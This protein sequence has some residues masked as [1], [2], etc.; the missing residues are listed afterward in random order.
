MNSTEVFVLFVSGLGVG[1]SFPAW[2]T[3]IKRGKS[4]G[5]SAGTVTATM[6]AASGTLLWSIVSMS[7]LLN[8]G[9]AG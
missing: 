7:I 5:S 2:I 9:A 6:L 1:L 4:E 8:L 3:T